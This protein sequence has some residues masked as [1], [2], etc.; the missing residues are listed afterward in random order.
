M[1]L[2]FSQRFPQ[3]QDRA[4]SWTGAVADC[5][6]RLGPMRRGGEFQPEIFDGELQPNCSILQRYNNN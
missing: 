4:S 3:R 6:E 2:V 5:V 1:Q